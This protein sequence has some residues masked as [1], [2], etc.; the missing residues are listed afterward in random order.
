MKG[1]RT[2]AFSF[3]SLSLSPSLPVFSLLQH[4]HNKTFGHILLKHFFFLNNEAFPR[5][6]KVTR[7]IF[8][9]TLLCLISVESTSFCDKCSGV[10]VHIYARHIGSQKPQRQV[11]FW[12]PAFCPMAEVM[13]FIQWHI[14]YESNCI[15]YEKSKVLAVK[16]H[17]KL[18]F[19]W[20]GEKR[21]R[22][23]VC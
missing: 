11:T 12:S 23:N 9:N 13:V 15:G 17:Q 14:Y 16:L 22:I 6:L 19:L 2:L 4:L 20:F 18:R 1:H 21:K 8:P 5:H 3:S 7:V 10:C